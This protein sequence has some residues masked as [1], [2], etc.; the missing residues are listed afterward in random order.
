MDEELPSQYDESHHG[1]SEQYPG[2]SEDETLGDN[3]HWADEYQHILAF[4]GQHGPLVSPRANPI[5]AS[6]PLQPEEEPLRA[7]RA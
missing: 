1:W 4:E 2:Q 5:R 3:V 6:E 7:G